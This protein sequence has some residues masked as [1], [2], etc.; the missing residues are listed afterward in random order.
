MHLRTVLVI[1]LIVGL[2]GWFLHQANLSDVWQ[3]V[4]SA[5]VDL[6]VLSFFFVAATYWARTVRWHYLLAPVGPTTFRSVFRTT[7][8]GFAALA[9]L[10]ARVGD[11]IR[12]YL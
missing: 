11:V 5:R 8:L 2:L 7:V 6:L 10:P 1:L 12:P 3:H 9:L 4:R